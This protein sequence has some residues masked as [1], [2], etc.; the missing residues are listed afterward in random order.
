MRPTSA[1]IA[2][3]P[4]NAGGVRPWRSRTGFTLLEMMVAV[5]VIAIVLLAVYRLHSQTL[6]MNQSAQFYSLAPVLA[7]KKLAELES[8]EDFALLEPNG[9][10]GDN[11]PGYRWE[12]NTEAVFSESLPDIEERFRRIDLKLTFNQD[13]LTYEIRTYRLQPPQDDG[14]R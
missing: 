11:Y 13:E 4:R 7:Q 8:N 3:N 12:V 10:F 2:A 6:L 14:R 1:T 5:S 9:D